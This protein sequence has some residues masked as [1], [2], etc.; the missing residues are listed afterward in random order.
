MAYITVLE[1][2]FENWPQAMVNYGCLTLRPK[3]S[4]LFEPKHYSVRGDIE[5][6]ELHSAPPRAFGAGAIEWLLSTAQ[7]N[8]TLGRL[9]KTILACRG[10]HV[11][12][13]ATLIDGTQFVG[14][15]NLRTWNEMLALRAHR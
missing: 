1:G 4:P 12:F 13:T 7:K 8:S 5:I 14:E 2:D 10:S 9:A 3:N 6:L 15:C 11:V